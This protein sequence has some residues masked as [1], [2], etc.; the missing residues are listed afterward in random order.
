MNYTKFRIEETRG[1][2]YRVLVKG[3]F[4]Y[5]SGFVHTNF[6]DIDYDSFQLAEI[7]IDRY[8]NRLTNIKDNT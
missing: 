8:R 1:D 7:A 4:G 3:W 5:I 2:K 6:F